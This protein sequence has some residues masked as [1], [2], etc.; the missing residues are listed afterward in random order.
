MLS[1]ATAVAR[2]SGEALRP[3]SDVTEQKLQTQGEKDALTPPHLGEA[4]YPFAS[5][6]AVR[7]VECRPRTGA[8]R[9]LVVEDDPLTL[10][11]LEM[12]FGRCGCE[13]ISASTVAEGLRLLDEGPD[14]LVLDMSLPD[15]L[16]L[17]ILARIRERKI[18][19]CIAVTTGSV[20]PVLLGAA[21]SLNPDV[22]LQKPVD[23]QR[24]L[25][26]FGVDLS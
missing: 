3:V 10:A 12:V 2:G 11:A 25:S 4:G 17:E 5:L 23:A 6:T 19:V 18:P 20:D 8:K 7:Q 24:L 22:L 1:R 9:I 16:G 13:V 14:C 21:A 15:G 26:T